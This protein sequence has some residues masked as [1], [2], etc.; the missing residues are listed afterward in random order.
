MKR[1]LAFALLMAGVI[2]ALVVGIV[3]KGRARIHQFS[4]QI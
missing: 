4:S 1:H 3:N 2:A